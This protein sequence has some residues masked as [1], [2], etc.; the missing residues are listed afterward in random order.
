MAVIN[1]ASNQVIADNVKIAD[2]FWPRFKGL[3][4]IKSISEDFALHLIPCTSIHTFFMKFPIDVLYLDQKNNIVG[5]EENL[6]PGKIG[7]KFSHAHS[8]IELHAGKVAQTGM[9]VGQTLTIV[10]MEGKLSKRVVQ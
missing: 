10:D 9:T 5:M 3:M 6:Q 8:V 1:L 4:G 2:S 7:K